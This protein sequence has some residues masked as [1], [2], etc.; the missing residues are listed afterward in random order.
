[1]NW[2]D[3]LISNAAAFGGKWLDANSP[4]PASASPATVAP[5]TAAAATPAWLV[6]VAI[7]LAVVLVLFVVLRKG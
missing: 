7:G 2:F 4:K 1:M 6:P 3:S 5:T